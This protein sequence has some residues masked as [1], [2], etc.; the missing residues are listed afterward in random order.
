M[1]VRI[2]HCPAECFTSTRSAP[3][4]QRQRVCQSTVVARRSSRHAGAVVILHVS[5]ITCLLLIRLAPPPIYQMLYERCRCLRSRAVSATVV[6]VHNHGHLPVAALEWLPPRYK[7]PS[8]A[9]RFG[10]PAYRRT[11]VHAMNS[12]PAPTLSAVA[13]A[14]AASNS[15]HSSSV[16]SDTALERYAQMV[17]SC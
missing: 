17:V 5:L 6:A 8:S 3:V 13:G 14:N 10:T 12:H 1:R 2:K 11:V 16:R 9:N 7:R 15:R 4:M